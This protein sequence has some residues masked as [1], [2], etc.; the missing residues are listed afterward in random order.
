MLRMYQPFPLWWQLFLGTLV[1]EKMQLDLLYLF[2]YCRVAVLSL[3]N[4]IVSCRS[5]LRLEFCVQYS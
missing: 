3:F 2:A 1:R 4:C 5:L